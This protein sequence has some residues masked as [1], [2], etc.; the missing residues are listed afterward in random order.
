M[1]NNTS[2]DRVDYSALRTNQGFIIALLLVA[3]IVYLWWLVAFVALVMI[4]GTIFTGAGLFKRIY[5]HILKPSGL[6]QP[7]V[8][9]DNPEPHNFSQGL[10]GAFLAG[11]TAALLLSAPVVGWVLAWIVIALAAL[12]LFGGFC[13]GCFAYYQLN[14]LG[15]PG[16]G[17]APLDTAVLPGTQPRKV[18]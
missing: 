14:K 17:R 8:V 2:L 13:V 16:F 3:F 1:G 11:S 9:S 12:N 15:T 10:G 4:V 18:G 5:R 6:V 7:D